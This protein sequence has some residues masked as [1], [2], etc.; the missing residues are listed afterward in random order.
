MRWF[1]DLPIGRKL[2][3]IILLTSGTALVLGCAAGV[4]YESVDARRM[5]VQDTTLLA[6]AVASNSTAA[7][8]FND[9]RGASEILDSLRIQPS[10]M[11]ACIYSHDGKPFATYTRAAE[12]FKDC[13]S[14]PLPDGSY[15]S[16]DSLLY[17]HRIS[18]SGKTIGMVYIASD[19]LPLRLRTRRT[20]FIF[21]LGIGGC[22]MVAFFIAL[23]LQ[24]LISSPLLALVDTA[25]KVTVQKDYGLRVAGGGRDELGVLIESFNQM[26]EQIQQRDDALKSHRERL[27]QEVERR[28]AELRETNTQL[29]VTKH[30]AEA[31]SR[32]KSEFLANMSHEI[33]TPMNGVLGMTEL[34]LDTN[35]T[36]E[37]REYLVAVKSSG[38][39]LLHLLNDILD[40]S[41][42]EAG[43]LDLELIEFNL[44][45]CLGETVRTLALRAH[46]KGLELAYELAAEVPPWVV[47]DPARLRQV[48]VNLIGNA[49][50]FTLRGEV[51]LR[52]GAAARDD[53]KAHLHFT[54]SDTGIGIPKDKQRAIFEVFAQADASTTRLYGGSGLGLAITARLIELMGGRISVES[55]EG[56]GS[57]FEFSV[58]LAVSSPARHPSTFPAP[59]IL[60]EVPVLVVDDNQTNREILVHATRG[61][62]MAP[63]AVGDGEA[64]IREMESALQQAKAYRVAL[65]DMHMPGMDGFELAERLQHDPRMAG[66]V[67]MMLTS[68]GQRGD[69]ARC[70]Q[71]GI[72]AYLVKPIGSYELMQALLAAL[73]QHAA[74][75]QNAEV[76]RPLVTRHTLRED[77]RGLRI[78]VAEDNPVNQ[79]LILRVLQKQGHAP[80]LAS[81][82]REAVALAASGRFDVAFMDVQMPEMDGF[83]ATAAIREREKVNGAH[84]PIYAMTA[85]ALKGDEERCLAAGMDGYISK[86]V[87]FSKIQQVLD[88]VRA[89]PPH[90]TPVWDQRQALSGVAGDEHL[91]REI[92][93]MFLKQYPQTVS[94]LRRAL[95][96]R[97]AGMLGQIAHRLK[98]EVGCFGA[99]PSLSALVKLEEDVAHPDFEPISRAVDEVER[100][101]ACLRQA[102]EEFGRVPHENLSR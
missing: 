92:A 67:I 98:G 90:P 53:G 11:N 94:D 87:N 70:R 78:L 8:T 15:F 48:L 57:R 82:G 32:A 91:L 56:K 79:A 17:F 18:L 38:E 2:I 61:W 59:E 7:L 3:A 77:H 13:P 23:R 44:H 65:I 55:E 68:S 20:A 33:R 12:Q 6:D 66:A 102:L 49:V 71:L 5:L 22:L 50:K 63:C 58:P 93:E 96:G 35:L 54:I 14:P 19:L 25:R 62:G 34:A 24:R 29:T 89:Q 4:V 31:A 99:A 39:S 47:G 30:A 85:H 41:K 76:V 43:K 97:D 28:T 80:E 36:G 37:Q 1:R 81:T 73:G 51:V 52:V 21:A 100:E 86:P 27:E 88:G 64:A 46:E 10:V 95:A 16:R 40:F 84:L 74:L 9:A 83:A 45:D 26:L 69:A 60:R 72:A 75:G 101:L 42:V